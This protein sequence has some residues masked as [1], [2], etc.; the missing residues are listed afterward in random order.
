[1]TD[2]LDWTHNVVD[3]PAAGLTREREAT[4]SERQAI[5]GALG[6]LALER[7]LARYR[8][9]ALAGGGYRLSGKI[10]ADVDQA[11]VVTLEPVNARIE[12]PFSVEFW[13]D[14]EP[15][16]SEE[17]VRALAAPEVEKFERDIIPAGRI[18]FETLASSLDPYPR[19]DG[20]E[21]NWQDPHADEP[22]KASPFAVLSKFKDKD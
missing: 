11:C 19:R 9:E 3:I 14:L 5:I 6:L 12:E 17:D 10:S 20:V 1:M 2:H 18:I 7:L 22:E 8:I 15:D 21:F 16:D 4:E 13:P